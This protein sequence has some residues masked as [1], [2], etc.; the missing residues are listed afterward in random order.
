MR[1]DKISVGIVVNLGIDR[2]PA[3]VLDKEQDGA[4]VA[5]R[6]R[7]EGK[8]RGCWVAMPADKNVRT[9]RR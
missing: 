4:M 5:L 3:V 8:R 1:A 2:E 9:L 6:L 7:Q